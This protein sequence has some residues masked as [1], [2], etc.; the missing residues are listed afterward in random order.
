VDSTPSGVYLQLAAT[1][2][3]EADLEVDVLRKKNFRAASM[4]VPE[5]PGIFRVLV[6][7]IPDGG[8]NRVREDL[9]DA[10]FPGKSAIVRR[11]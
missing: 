11:F 7:P 3:H 1:T 4:E 9:Q 6:G 2:R 5:K 10:G 8:V